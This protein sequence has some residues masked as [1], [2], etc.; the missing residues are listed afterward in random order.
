MNTIILFPDEIAG[1]GRVC[2]E[3]RRADHIHT[4][5]GA[6]I[7]KSVRVGVLNGG[8]GTGTIQS[9]DDK[10]VV[11]SCVIDQPP[12]PESRVDLLLAMPRP[13]VLKRLW[14]QV[15]AMGVRRV[16]LTNANKVERSYFDSHWN[17]PDYYRERMIEGLEQTGDTRLPEV[18]IKKRLK[19]FLEDELDD[20]FPDSRR[21]MAHPEPDARPRVFMPKNRERMLIAVGPEGGWTDYELDLFAAHGFARASLGWRV[22]R[23][24]TAC[25]ALLALAGMTERT[26]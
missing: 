9:N 11:L 4:I 12:P 1:D 19:I 20:M 17:R 15:T 22:L 14:P 23:T 25:V 2:L 26:Q 8:R 3:G 24:E 6:D 10:K 18:Q 16:I 7:G 21:V 13:L 5:L